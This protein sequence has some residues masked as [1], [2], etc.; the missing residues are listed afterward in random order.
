MCIIDDEP[1]L[2][3]CGFIML[4]AA[5]SKGAVTGLSYPST[6]DFSGC[7]LRQVSPCSPRTLPCAQKPSCAARV[8]LFR[9]APRVGL[10]RLSLDNRSPGHCLPGAVSASPNIRW[11]RLGR[12]MELHHPAPVV[13]QRARLKALRFSVCSRQDWRLLSLPEW[14]FRRAF[15]R[16][17][18]WGRP[19][20]ARPIAGAPTAPGQAA[21]CAR[22]SAF[23]L[24]L[25]TCTVLP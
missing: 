13:A 11:I 14:R 4:R 23:A 15:R 9:Y 1:W 18:C 7:Q 17:F 3:A 25:P 21:G 8:A 10:N 2:S 6:P 5:P 24:A 19:A 16:V 12:R 20:R 22:T